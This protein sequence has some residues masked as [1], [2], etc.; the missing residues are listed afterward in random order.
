M[1]IRDN[2]RQLFC[3]IKWWGLGCN[4]SCLYS[5]TDNGLFTH[6]MPTKYYHFVCY[7]LS[8]YLYV[9]FVYVSVCA[10]VQLE[11]HNPENRNKITCLSTCMFYISFYIQ[12]LPLL[13]MIEK[14]AFFNYIRHMGVVRSTRGPIHGVARPRAST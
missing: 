10:S 1:S 2:S 8:T 9:L 7:C 3:S 4:P 14:Y 5:S 11:I 12:L 13:Y 6:F